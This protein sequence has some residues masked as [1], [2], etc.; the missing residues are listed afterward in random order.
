MG[1]KTKKKQQPKISEE[2]RQIVSDSTQEFE[3]SPQEIQEQSETDNEIFD[4]L[5]VQSELQMNDDAEQQVISPEQQLADIQEWNNLSIQEKHAEMEKLREEGIPTTLPASLKIDS[6]LSD[7]THQHEDLSTL[8]DTDIPFTIPSSLSQEEI[9]AIPSDEELLSS[10]LD[11]DSQE[12]VSP[13]EDVEVVETSEDDFSL[14]FDDEASI[15]LQ[16]EIS[17]VFAEVES[18]SDIRVLSSNKKESKGGSTN[19]EVKVLEGVPLRSATPK[20][21]KEPKVRVS[22]PVDAQMQIVEGVEVQQIPVTRQPQARGEQRVVQHKPESKAARHMFYPNTRNMSFTKSKGS[23]KV[24]EGNEP[25]EIRILG[26]AESPLPNVRD[27][28]IAL[29]QARS[30]G[31]ALTPKKRVHS[32]IYGEEIDH[33]VL[34]SSNSDLYD[35]F[36]YGLGRPI[37]EVPSGDQVYQLRFVM[38]EYGGR[39]YPVV[40]TR[41]KR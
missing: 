17:S 6:D 11:V 41:I 14:S 36:G 13:T 20:T 19:T 22:I 37:S 29:A 5:Q 16:N 26:F 18:G 35:L 2:L 8:K 23:Q 25:S 3:L 30:H 39:Q 27:L 1:T 7:E 15:D 38:V 28:Q 24:N 10:P 40:E 31:E 33:V 12:D 34:D 21:S 4:Q 32:N 9:D